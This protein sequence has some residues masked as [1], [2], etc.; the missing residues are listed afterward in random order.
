M[1]RSCRRFPGYG[2][3]MR[4]GHASTGR[5]SSRQASCQKHG[6]AGLRPPA[7]LGL[8]PVSDPFFD[9]KHAPDLVLAMFSRLLGEPRPDWPRQTVVTGFAFYDGETE[10]RARDLARSSTPGHDRSS[11]RSARR[12]SS[13]RASSSGKAPAVRRSP[14]AAPCCSSVPSPTGWPS[15]IDA[16]AHSSTRLSQDS[17]PKPTSSFI[18]GDRERPARQC[19]PAVP[20]WSCRTHTTSRTTR[21]GSA[22]WNLRDDSQGPMYSA[23]RVAAAL[24]RIAARP[25][26]TRRA[27]QVGSI[28]SHEDGAGGRRRRDRTSVRRLPAGQSVLTTL[29]GSRCEARRART[30]DAA[31]AGVIR[32]RKTAIILEC[33]QPEFCSPSPSASRARRVRRCPET[34]LPPYAKGGRR[35]RL[36]RHEGAGSVPVDGGLIEAEVADWVAAQNAVTFR[37]LDQLPMRDD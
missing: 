9:D 1:S 26:G 27:A 5:S 10:S 19:A 30:S 20:W 7:P 6:A 24:E 34:G 17:F 32:S 36:L 13:I 22:S 3:F 2:G 23:A 16:S 37:Y 18:R 33:V 31:V 8:P 21:C 11:S 14:D 28:V 15:P 29:I 12:R 25:E 4:W 35:R